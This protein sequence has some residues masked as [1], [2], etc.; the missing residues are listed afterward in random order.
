MCSV[1][2]MRKSIF[3]GILLSG[4]ALVYGCG[5]VTASEPEEKSHG[6]LVGV[7]NVEPPHNRPTD[8]PTNR[9]VAVKGKPLFSDEVR[10]L[11]VE[12]GINQGCYVMP[13]E[14]E[15]ED[16]AGQAKTRAYQQYLRGAWLLENR[17]YK[18][19]LE[20]FEQASS[21]DPESLH[22]RYS[23]AA[24][25][26]RLGKF[27]KVLEVCEAILKMAPGTVDALILKAETFAAMDNYRKAQELYEQVLETEP[28]NVRALEALGK[29]YFKVQGNLDK[30]ISVY[31]KILSVN[32][33][34]LYALVILGSVYALKDDVD[35]SLAYY[36]RVLQ[37]QPILL[38][39]FIEMGELMEKHQQYEGALK[40]YR[41]AIVYDSKNPLALRNFKRLV[42]K[43]KGR[44]GLLAAY[45]ALAEEYPVVVELQE[46]YAS[47]LMEMGRY[48]EAGKQ[49]GV[50][51]ALS[52][53]NARVQVALA[54]IALAEGKEE[55][56]GAALRK[57]VGLSLNKAD[58]YTEL[59]LFCQQQKAYAQAVL[60][61]EQA[62]ELA[63]KN[64]VVIMH[65]LR[66]YYR[67]QAY[68]K[69]EAL[70]KQ[71]IAENEKSHHLH[72]L[73]GE[74]YRDQKNT[75][76]AIEAYRKAVALKPGELSYVSA[77]GELYLQTDQLEE[78]Q[79][80]VQ[81]QEQHFEKNAKRF[82]MLIAS[83]YN[84][85]GK[86]SKAL[87][88]LQKALAID[89]TDLSLYGYLSWTYN[90]LHQY[91][92]AIEILENAK[93]EL[94]EKAQSVEYD[95]LLATV[96][97]DQ[98]KYDQAVALYEK[99]L[100]RSPTN[101]EAYRSIMFCLNKQGKHKKT[102]DY[103]EKAEKAIGKEKPEVVD[104]R[105]QALVDQEKYEEA[106]AIY[107]QLI[108][109]DKTNDRYYFLLGEVYYEGKRFTDAEAA[110]RKAIE[111][112]ENNVDAY[113]NLGYMFA[114]NNMHLDEAQK[115]I[116]K[117]L[118]LRP[119]AGYIIDSLGWVYFQKGDVEKALELLEKAMSLSKDDP[120]MFD[121][122]GD[123]Y[124]AK[125]EKAKALKYWERAIE[126]DPSMTEVQ[127][128][129]DELKK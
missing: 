3:L 113:N 72:V 64:A 54:K 44:D 75:Q 12:F 28:E 102:L 70:I 95:M 26:L 1:V 89:P 36:D 65:L 67:L 96:Y 2:S 80:F 45:R 23:I 11:F 128:K 40:V 14:P 35:K 90:R 66:A 41:R 52:P 24:C 34:D 91:D 30:T 82:D 59:G 39:K 100:E 56:A 25:Y 103:V 60:Y 120:V 88:Y 71:S 118:E 116:E 105:A 17:L 32:P 46:L 107:Q 10:E 21:E 79:T 124:R 85:Y 94:G 122:L 27:E 62:K 49:F 78:F 109:Q 125:G 55:E 13:A 126:L 111:L 93:A 81:A 106:A 42:L 8:Q 129:I 61:F 69:M 15:K 115:L 76:A 7:Q 98:K 114:E 74:F 108:D 63:P 86:F 117:A 57:A 121:H 73:L 9:Q 22:I 19:A 29:I 68:D 83:F 16:K 47:Q 6:L 87:P 99:V 4:M 53:D 123:A 112:N 51:Q 104:L 127:K 110:F 38:N 119:N 31:E 58:V 48:E 33:K 37:H 84:D 5:C 18:E 97:T 101:I 50:V 92:Q 20:H 43:L 77:L